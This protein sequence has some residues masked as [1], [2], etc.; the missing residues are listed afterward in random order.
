MKSIILG[1]IDFIF[2]HVLSPGRVMGFALKF[3]PQNNNPSLSKR[4]YN[5]FLAKWGRL[6]NEI[7]IKTD[8]SPRVGRII[9][10]KH[11]ASHLHYDVSIFDGSQKVDT[12]R[13]SVSKADWNS[14]FP[15]HSG[16]PTSFIRQ[17]NHLLEYCEQKHHNIPEGE[18]GAGTVDKVFDSPILIHKTDANKI[19]FSLYDKEISGRFALLNIGKAWMLV[20]KKD[21]SLPNLDRHSYRSIKAPVR[22]TIAEEKVDGNNEVIIID[23][24]GYIHIKGTRPGVDGRMPIHTAH[25]S[26]ITSAPRPEFKD[27]IL[28]GELFHKKGVNFLSGLLNSKPPKAWLTQKMHGRVTLHVFDI[29]RYKGKD[30]THLPYSERRAIYLGLCKE[31]HDLS[32]R[33]V[34][35]YSNPIA[36]FAV[37]KEGLV[38]KDPNSAY[39]AETWLKWK[40]HD[41]EDLK[42]VDIV[43]VKDV[44]EG[45]KWFKDGLPVGTGA[46]IVERNGVHIKV[47]SGIPDWMRK[48]SFDNPQKY[49]GA[50]AK[51]EFMEATDKG[52]LRA[53]RFVDLH[54][55]KSDPEL[56]LRLFALGGGA[57]TEQETNETIYRLKSSAGWRRR[58]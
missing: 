57:K 43:P 38:F 30:V 46:F 45:S 3:D 19:S 55:Q 18:Y 16:K 36:G 1:S 5:K 23:E 40:H 15:K 42:I 4:T 50:V 13:L 6:P 2:D 32:I 56:S 21:L 37:E 31:L 25:A 9:I 10:Q 58:V 41:D 44:V 12:I 20:R 29:T 17:P 39:K 26:H 33:P 51:I 27:T 28:H 14:L 24:D 49:I 7:P 11:R 52:S 34:K 53:P 35:S 48:D 47:G 22:N 8:Y 54:Y